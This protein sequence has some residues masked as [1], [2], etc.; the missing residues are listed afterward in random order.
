[1]RVQKHYK[2]RFTKNRV[3]KLLQKNRHKIPNLLFL[4]FI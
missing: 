3:E 4:D 2:K 1:M